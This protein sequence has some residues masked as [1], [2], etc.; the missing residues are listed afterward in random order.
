MAHRQTEGSLL[1]GALLL[2][3]LAFVLSW[4]AA[5]VREPQAL[6]YPVTISTAM[7]MVHGCLKAIRSVAD[8]LLLPLITVP[9]FLSVAVLY[10]LERVRAF[11]QLIWILLGLL[12]LVC[13]QVVPNIKGLRLYWASLMILGLGCLAI[14]I[15]LGV[16]EYGSKIWLQVG[17]I[18]F[19]PAELAK[20]LLALSLAG[21]LCTRKALLLARSWQ[22]GR[23]RLPHPLH[24]GPLLMA[25]AVTLVLMMVQRDLGTALL[26]FG[27]FSCQLYVAAPRWDYLL[28]EFIVLVAGSAIGYRL[29]PHVRI[30]FDIWLSPWRYAY[31]QGYQ[32]VQAI[33]ATSAGGL[34][35]AGLGSGWPGLIPAVTTD[36]TFIAWT[37][38]MGLAGAIALI[39][40]YLLLTQRGL[41]ASLDSTDD[42]LTLAGVG[43]ISLFAL[44]SLV[45]IAGALRLM[46]L[47]GLTLPLFNY[48]GSSVVASMTGF[49]FILRLSAEE[50]PNES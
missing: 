21:Y 3:W 37:E 26:L 2:G 22:I 48:G 4:L 12:I 15:V 1:L 47:T 34:L 7:L 46:P 5:P 14:T 33:L 13:L 29:F 18:K 45:I 9:L 17:H 35:G 27:L 10:R 49:G 31:G 32:L 24:F 11:W 43:M 6:F 50:E 23:L 8:Q 42:F 36:L 20:I 41:K 19:Q 40:V 44:Q 16:K 39:L 38:E 28:L 30:R 25:V